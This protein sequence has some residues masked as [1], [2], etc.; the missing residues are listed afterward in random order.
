MLIGG[1]MIILSGYFFLARRRRRGISP[2][3]LAFRRLAKDLGYSKGQIT[4]IRKYA[5]AKGYPS[6]VG[7]VMSQELAARALQSNRK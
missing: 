4:Q 6:P 3:E 5:F 1:A 2:S 7:V